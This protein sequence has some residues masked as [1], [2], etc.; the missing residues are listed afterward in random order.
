M[1][2]EIKSYEVK[3]FKV[4]VIR[5]FRKEWTWSVVA[6]NGNII[7]RCTETYV[8]KSDVE[9]NIDSLGLSLVNNTKERNNNQ[10]K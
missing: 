1:S 3:I 9:Y 6:T 5:K 10:N 8:N 4:W 7:G 2:R